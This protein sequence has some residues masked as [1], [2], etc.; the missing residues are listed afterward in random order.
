MKK[1]NFAWVKSV[2]CKPIIERMYQH[3]HYAKDYELCH[4]LPG[5][6]GDH[7]T[8]SGN[9]TSSTMSYIRSKSKPSLCRKDN[10]LIKGSTISLVVSDCSNSTLANL[11]SDTVYIPMT[12]DG[13]VSSKTLFACSCNSFQTDN[14]D[15]DIL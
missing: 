11:F 5:P 13:D 6:T 14:F 8:A 3:D 2:K 9:I 7:L 15:I 1:P 10:K 12:I 4:L